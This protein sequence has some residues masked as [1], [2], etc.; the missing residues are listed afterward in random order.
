MFIKLSRWILFG[1]IFSILPFTLVVL[2][3]WGI[4][5]K[6]YELEYLLDL[7]LITFAIA[8]NALSLITDD[9][10]QIHPG[11]KM[12]CG[13]LSIISMLLCISMYFYFFEYYLVT[14]KMLEQ[15]TMFDVSFENNLTNE[16]IFRKLEVLE[17]MS[18]EFSP[19]GERLII[20][21]KISVAILIINLIVGIVV[22]VADERQRQRNKINLSI[23]NNDESE[24][25][26]NRV[27]NH[28]E[29]SPM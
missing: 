7:L 6:I 25:S 18:A 1:V 12:I 5:H 11:M 4:N 21:I 9:G 15:Y 8:T 16:D 17:Q 20:L 26:N 24:K 14:N 3:N 19:N 2:C 28:E 29:E 13:A 22:E 27:G 23:D 10:K